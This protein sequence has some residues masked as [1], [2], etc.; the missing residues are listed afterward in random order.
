MRIQDLGMEPIALKDYPEYSCY[1]SMKARCFNPNVPGYHNYGGRGITVCERWLGP[2]GFKTFLLDAGRRPTSRHSL[3]RW[4]NNDGNYEPGNVRWATVKQQASNR[5]T[6]K[7]YEF[8][9][10]NKTIPEWA[11]DLGIRPETLWF[12][13]KH[14]P[15]E[16]A[17]TAGLRDYRA[18][19]DTERSVTKKLLAEHK[20]NTT[21]LRILLA[22]VHGD[23]GEN[24]IEHGIT[25]STRQAITQILSMKGSIRDTRTNTGTTP[26]HE[27]IGPHHG[28]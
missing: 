9:G 5:R 23:C 24:R 27:S 26:N 17:L 4:P 11:E 1:A 7:R 18:E 12:R 3:D 2:D 22:T 28:A 10:Q 19:S 25:E 14:W 15:I 21:L 8:N 6:V 20:T 13:I 16:R